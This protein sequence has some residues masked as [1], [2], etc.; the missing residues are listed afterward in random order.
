MPSRA[1]RHSIQ[2]AKS[3]FPARDHRKCCIAP[4][5]ASRSR[6]FGGDNCKNWNSVPILSVYDRRIENPRLAWP[7]LEFGTAG[8]VSCRATSWHTQA[9]KTWSICSN[10]LVKSPLPA[11]APLES[12]SARE[13]LPTVFKI[14]IQ[15]SFYFIALQDEMEGWATKYP[16]RVDDSGEVVGAAKPFSLSFSS[17]FEDSVRD[18]G[19][20]EQN[21][22][23]TLVWELQLC[24][25]LGFLVVS[26]WFD[27]IIKF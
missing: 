9:L 17:V 12:S 26:H 14:V 1:R 18:P 20:L 27:C 16:V 23:W 8:L 10:A 25:V 24:P 22:H 7:P 4:P 19:D 5:Q 11:P 15:N 13:S 6:A 3:I 2:W 21:K